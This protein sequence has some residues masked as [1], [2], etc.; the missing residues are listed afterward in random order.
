MQRLGLGGRGAPAQFL[1]PT[2][3]PLH[4]A[5]FGHTKV[6]QQRRKT[7]NMDIRKRV[8]ARG[9]TNGLPPTS[10]LSFS[11]TIGKWPMDKIGRKSAQMSVMQTPN[12]WFLCPTKSTVVKDSQQTKNR[13]LTASGRG[14]ELEGI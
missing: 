10:F 8:Q 5:H 12:T 11:S 13:G 6:L 3:D 1:D 2:E 4:M 7:G 9:S 14:I